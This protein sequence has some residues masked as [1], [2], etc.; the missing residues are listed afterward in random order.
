MIYG[1]SKFIIERMQKSVTW[2]PQKPSCV[3]VTENKSLWL[4]GW[5]WVWR[6]LRLQ[7]LQKGRPVINDSEVCAFSLHATQL[8]GA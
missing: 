5:F 4:S 6:C 3:C 2:Q 1:D 7:V 8:A